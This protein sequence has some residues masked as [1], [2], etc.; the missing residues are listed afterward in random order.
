MAN[1]LISRSAG[2]RIHVKSLFKDKAHITLCWLYFTWYYVVLS[3]QCCFI[4]CL[5]LN[6]KAISICSRIPRIHWGPTCKEEM[7]KYWTSGL[8][9]MCWRSHK[10]HWQQF[11][12][13]RPRDRGWVTRTIK[14]AKQRMVA[15]LNVIFTFT[16]NSWL[17]MKFYKW[18]HSLPIH[19][20]YR[21]MSS[22]QNTKGI[23]KRSSTHCWNTADS[24]ESRDNAHRTCSLSHSPHDIIINRQYCY[25]QE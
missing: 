11:T 24:L 7:V 8:N 17:E 23:H 12:A 16:Q 14:N 1:G 15:K 25:R 22:F 6:N 4:C 3:S 19:T 5:W 18:W 13:G 9:V 2:G 20:R 10:T 21:S